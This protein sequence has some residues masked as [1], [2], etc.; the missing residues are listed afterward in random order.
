[1][2][3]NKLIEINIKDY[4]IIPY[5]KIKQNVT[6]PINYK[7]TVR[8]TFNKTSFPFILK[9]ED[10]N[11]LIENRDFLLS[12]DENNNIVL[13]K[14]INE[15][16]KIIENLD[17]YNGSIYDIIKNSNIKFL[18]KKVYCKAIKSALDKYNL[19][20]LEGFDD[21]PDF[22]ELFDDQT[23]KFPYKKII[24]TSILSYIKYKTA[25]NPDLISHIDYLENGILLYKR[26]KKLVDKIRKNNISEMKLKIDSFEKK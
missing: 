3:E 18:T 5:R 20:K 24:Y 14:Y 7:K 16:K 17:D 4:N 23:I 8:I 2:N 25:K 21:L 12:K 6:F 15:N 10:K 13:G 19:I 22:N 9:I 1:M 11:Y 26:N